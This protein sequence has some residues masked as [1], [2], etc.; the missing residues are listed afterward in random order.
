MARKDA[1][2]ESP[3][4]RWYYLEPGEVQPGGPVFL[5]DLRKLLEKREIHKKAIVWRKGM[6]HWEPIENVPQLKPRSF[7]SIFGFGRKTQSADEH[8]SLKKD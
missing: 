5:N 8:P 4:E 3:Q 7:L 6:N 1:T 2:P